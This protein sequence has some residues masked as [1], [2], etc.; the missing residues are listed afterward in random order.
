M[1]VKVA[2]KDKLS[3]VLDSMCRG[4]KSSLWI[5]ALRLFQWRLTKAWWEWIC[6]R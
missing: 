2:Q 5:P 4:M 1:L 3:L 6:K